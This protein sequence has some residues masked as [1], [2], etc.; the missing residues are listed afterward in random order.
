MVLGL[1]LSLPTELNLFK[2]RFFRDHRLGQNPPL[3]LAKARTTLSCLQLA[4]LA[5]GHWLLAMGQALGHA[6]KPSS[7]GMEQPCNTLI[8]LGRPRC[9]LDTVEIMTPSL[10]REDIPVFLWSLCCPSKSY[11]TAAPSLPYV[12]RTEQESFGFLISI[13]RSYHFAPEMNHVL[14]TP[15][16]SASHVLS[17]ALPP[18]S[19]S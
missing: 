5:L 16:S 17:L 8:G 3:C 19:A 9:N 7:L 13:S 18:Q 4:S 15:L 6:T 14:C 12:A 2:Q 11:P 10:D 1:S